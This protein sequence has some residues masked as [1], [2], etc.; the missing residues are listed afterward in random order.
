PA[1]NLSR[2]RAASRRLSAPSGAGAKRRGGCH[3]SSP[4]RAVPPT[5][6]RNAL[7]PKVGF[8]PIAVIPSRVARQPRTLGG[9]LRSCPPASA[10]RPPPPPLLRSVGHPT[11][12]S[13]DGGGVPSSSRAA[14][15]P[16]RAGGALCAAK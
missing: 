5:T 12:L 6:P 8:L 11:S 2:R 1:T 7:V 9:R 13:G 15:C 16:E 14:A 10:C 4:W 3:F